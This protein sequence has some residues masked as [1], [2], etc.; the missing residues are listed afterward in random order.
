MKRYTATIPPGLS[1]RVE[2]SGSLLIIARASFGFKLAVDDETETD[3]ESGYVVSEQFDRA[4]FKNEHATKSLRISYH[5]G[6]RGASIYDSYQLPPTVI[7]C[8]EGTLATAASIA[9]ATLQDTAGRRRAWI[10]IQNR[11]AAG[12][13][14]L[15]IKDVDGVSGCRI[16]PGKEFMLSSDDDISLNNV[17]GSDIDYALTIAFYA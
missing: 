12:T 2:R 4:I 15:I 17:G 5:L 14:P 11:N 9:A 1:H 3:A 13:N 6:Q 8:V 7:K 16:L 10:L